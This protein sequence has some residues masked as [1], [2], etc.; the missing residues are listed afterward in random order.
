MVFWKLLAVM[1]AFLP[2]LGCGLQPFVQPKTN[3]VIEEGIGSV[4]T[5]A[6]TAERR[7]AYVRRADVKIAP[8]R[9]SA[10]DAESA[11]LPSR[12]VGEPNPNRILLGRFGGKEGEYCAEPSPDSIESLA[13]AFSLA[14]SGSGTKL[15]SMS[16]EL[17][18]DFAKTLATTAASIFRRTQGVQLYRDGAF[19]L[20]Q[21][22][23]NGYM[24]AYEY[25]QALKFLRLDAVDLIKEEMKGKAWNTPFPPT[26][27]ADS[28][29]PKD[30]KEKTPR[31]AEPSLPT[32][33]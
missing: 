4:Q 26:K 32:S 18:T 24:D 17:R 20:C 12:Q 27:S 1:P 7:L 10:V 3:P 25:R 2:I 14:A 6:T 30:A 19:L 22:M 31:E 28:T 15:E 9:V 16:A 33:N 5:V 11:R 13:A 21:A 8:V 29:L 23:M